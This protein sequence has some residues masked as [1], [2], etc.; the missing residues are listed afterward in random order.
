MWSFSCLE[1]RHLE[2]PKND[3]MTI[4][5]GMSFQGDEEKEIS[6]EDTEYLKVQIKTQNKLTTKK[7]D[8]HIV[9]FSVVQ[10]IVALKQLCLT[11][12]HTL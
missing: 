4:F 6:E 10:R 1:S 12:M 8:K 9:W 3:H 7:V 11:Y 5:G 2:G